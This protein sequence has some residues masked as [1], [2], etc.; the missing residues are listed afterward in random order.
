MRTK[1]PRR[2]R[3]PKRRTVS[4][5]YRL[6]G[7]VVRFI[8]I[9]ADQ[10]PKEVTRLQEVAAE[11]L[12]QISE[13]RFRVS[14]PIIQQAR[15]ILKYGPKPLQDGLSEASY[16]LEVGRLNHLLAS[17]LAVLNSM[18]SEYP[19]LKRARFRLRFGQTSHKRE[20]GWNSF[21]NRDRE[22]SAEGDPE[23]PAKAE[24]D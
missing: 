7:P 8:D 21:N 14:H 24:D 15:Y 3:T 6:H 13:P 22:R 16:V 17:A 19:E 11:V 5:T 20:M 12:K 4:M 18:R 2:P 23:S 10:L 9:L 1:K